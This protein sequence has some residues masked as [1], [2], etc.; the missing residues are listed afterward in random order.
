[1]DGQTSIRIGNV[2]FSDF[3]KSGKAETFTKNK[4]TYN[5]ITLNTKDLLKYTKDDIYNYNEERCFWGKH[6][7]NLDDYALDILHKTKNSCEI[8][9]MSL[10][11]IVN[12]GQG[13]ESETEEI[14][15]GAISKTKTKKGEVIKYHI[16]EGEID[17]YTGNTKP[18]GKIV[19]AH[20]EPVFPEKYLD[21][22]YNLDDRTIK[23]IKDWYGL[24]REKKS[25]EDIGKMWGIKRNRVNEI[26]KIAVH[27]LR[28]MSQDEMIKPIRET[29]QN[30]YTI[31]DYINALNE[32]ENN[33]KHSLMKKIKR[34]I[35]D[36]S[37][38][39]EYSRIKKLEDIINEWKKQKEI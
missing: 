8:L 10:K 12:K 33:L 36:D 17:L 39:Q 29:N 23:I 1:M 25:P 13:H 19:R 35:I 31:R 27:R 28:D 34:C 32:L 15:R 6:I 4:K 5:K 18:N 3:I 37:I 16:T 21:Y 38:L 22:L 11:H 30:H 26:V 14:Y 24:F 7:Y 2:L 9:I 20:R